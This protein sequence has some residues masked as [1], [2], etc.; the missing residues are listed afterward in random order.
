MK[1]NFPN[2]KF[3]GGIPAYGFKVENNKLVID[4]NE[5]KIVK[6]LFEIYTTTD[7]SLNKIA[8]MFNEEGLRNR[9]G[10]NSHN[11]K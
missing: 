7:L 11:I 8:M 3:N 1:E 4:E 9:Q 5:Q 2:G 10:K 6:R